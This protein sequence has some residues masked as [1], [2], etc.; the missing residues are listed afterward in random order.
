MKPLVPVVGNY[1]LCSAAEGGFTANCGELPSIHDTLEKVRN[2]PIRLNPKKIYVRFYVRL[3]GID[4]ESPF[5]LDAQVVVEVLVTSK[6]RTRISISRSL[7]PPHV[8]ESVQT[9]AALGHFPGAYSL[10]LGDDKV[11]TWTG[12][13]LPLERTLYMKML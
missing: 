1:L 6:D 3:I 10:H 8:A 5:S 7:L 2:S 12:G 4:T 11:R 9:P 13:V